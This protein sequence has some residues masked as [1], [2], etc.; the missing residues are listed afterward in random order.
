[1][2]TPR[3]VVTAAAT[4]VVA[5][6]L[7]LQASGPTFWTV[8]T[9]TDFLRG[10]SDGAYISL[11]GVLTPGPALTSRLTA[12]PP[13]VWSLIDAG[14][15]TLIAGT[16]GDGKVLRLR[17]GQPEQ[18]LLDAEEPN[19]FALAASGTRVY[20]ATAPD[21]KVYAI[22][23]DGSSRVFFDPT[24]KYIWALAVDTRGNVY[25]GTGEKGIVY[26]GSVG[27]DEEMIPVVCK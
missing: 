8:A 22:E 1:M 27:T 9:A 24:E 25:A 11:N 23:A 7:A 3:F 13:Q 10:T 14:D 17:A 15:G 20:A 2:P 6:S 5:T 18:T 21:G 16:G 12:T 26:K 19:V 4:F